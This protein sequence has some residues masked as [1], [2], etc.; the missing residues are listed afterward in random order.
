[1]E[2]L[3]CL[4]QHGG[5]VVS[6]DRLI[7]DVWA[8]TP[9]VGDDVLIRCISELRRA[10]EDDAKAPRVIETIPKKGYRLLVEVEPVREPPVRS[11]PLLLRGVVAVMITT[12]I[13]AATYRGYNMFQK[14]GLLSIRRLTTSGHVEHVAISPD[15]KY[16][17]YSEDDGNAQSLWLREIATA[18]SAQLQARAAV[19]YKCLSFSANGAYVYYTRGSPGTSTDLFRIPMIGRTPQKL[20]ENVPG[21]FSLSPDGKSLVFVR[22]DPERRESAIVVAA[23]DGSAERELT[24]R[25]QPIFLAWENGAS[26]S[27]DGKL[28]ATVEVEL[29][30]ILQCR[31]LVIA[32]DSG[33]EKIRTTPTI[34]YCME[35]PQWRSDG[36]GLIAAFQNPHL[37][38]WEF[39]YPQAL[40]RRVTYDPMRYTEVS[41]SA[42]PHYIVAVQLDW[43][44]DIWVGP[45]NDP[46]RAFRVKRGHF[47]SNRGLGWMPSGE[48]LFETT[49]A[50]TYDFVQMRPDGT[51]ERI[52]AFSPDV[53][54]WPEVCSDGRTLLFHKFH[55]GTMT[56]MR[57][58]LSGFKPQPL[59]ADVADS[60]SRCSPDS[61]WVV[62]GGGG[63]LWKMPVSGSP[64]VLLIDKYC[65]IPS[66][67][68]DGRWIACLYWPGRVGPPKL[69]ILSF[70]GTTPVKT[71]ELPDSTYDDTYLGWT[72][73]DQAIAFIDNRSGVRNL[74][75]Q[76]LSGESAHALTHFSTEGVFDFA[77]SRD[78]AQI[79][80]ARGDWTSDAVMITNF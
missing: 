18:T 29:T 14:R 27:P 19:S 53:E 55:R 72:P 70:S 79:A 63:K 52:L 11:S 40:A 39:S 7:A 42:D 33:S 30:P 54:T 15:G 48:I 10:L 58:D 57:S 61:K 23:I 3:V 22:S 12:A 26:W 78:G 60:A 56:L 25:R 64:A 43:P 59:A 75:A 44:S 4:A 65:D 66:I 45:A 38:L 17:A 74:W 69:T 68:H 31:L 35:Q 20:R 73:D 46:D 28:I 16:L 67:S 24:I 77:W 36:R 76:P 1:M 71:L 50:D 34:Q 37:Q 41:L 49:A 13:A 32:A 80:I 5:S 2:V 21:R 62:Y 8:D 6:K 51:D 9:F 47:V